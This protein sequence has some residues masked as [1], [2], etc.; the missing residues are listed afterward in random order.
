MSGVQWPSDLAF[1]AARSY[2]AYAEDEPDPVRRCEL[3]MAMLDSDLQAIEWKAN[4]DEYRAIRAERGW[5]R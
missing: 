5:D 1:A 3:Y 2:G 4:E